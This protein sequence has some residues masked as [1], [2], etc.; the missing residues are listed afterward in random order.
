M[1]A[2][3][4]AAIL[5]TSRESA[6]ARIEQMR[7][8]AA[9]LVQAAINLDIDHLGDVVDKKV[10][11]LADEIDEHITDVTNDGF[12]PD[13]DSDTAFMRANLRMFQD[14]SELVTAFGA[15]ARIAWRLGARPGER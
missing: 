3:A 5:N 6:G 12:S 13:A 4:P 15:F 14:A 1:N 9:Q 2:P 11:E 10:R 8:I 7:T